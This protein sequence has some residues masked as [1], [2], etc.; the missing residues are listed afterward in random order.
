MKTKNLVVIAIIAILMAVGRL[1]VMNTSNPN[2]APFPAPPAVKPEEAAR[3]LSMAPMTMTLQAKILL[4]SRLEGREGKK[5]IVRISCPSIVPCPNNASVICQ[6][7]TFSFELDSNVYKNDAV[8]EIDDFTFTICK[9]GLLQ[10]VGAEMDTYG[11]PMLVDTF[12]TDTD[13]STEDAAT[14]WR[15]MMGIPSPAPVLHDEQ[16]SFGL[17]IRNCTLDLTR[18]KWLPKFND[19]DDDHDF[20]GELAH[21]EYKARRGSLWGMHHYVKTTRSLVR[22]IDQSVMADFTNWCL[23][24]TWHDDDT[25]HYSAGVAHWHGWGV[26]VNR[27]KAIALLNSSDSC[28]A[29]AK[30]SIMTCLYLLGDG[31]KESPDEAKT[32]LR[33]SRK[34]A[35]KTGKKDRDDFAL[36]KILEGGKWNPDTPTRHVFKLLEAQGFHNVR[37]TVSALS[38]GQ[39]NQLGQMLRV[40][41]TLLGLLGYEAKVTAP[42]HAA[43][44]LVDTKRLGHDIPQLHASTSDVGP[45]YNQTD[46]YGFPIPGKIA[47]AFYKVPGFAVITGLKY[48]N[49][50]FQIQGVPS[51]ESKGLLPMIFPEDIKVATALAFGYKDPVSA[52]LSLE[53]AKDGWDERN[54]QV[55]RKVFNPQWL[56]YTL[57]GKSLYW[58]DYL[59]KGLCV[60]SMKD[61]TLFTSMLPEYSQ[62]SLID[63][64]DHCG[65]TFPTGGGRNAIVLNGIQV[66]S[67]MRNGEYEAKIESISHGVEGSS[68]KM[69]EDGSEDRTLYWNDPKTHPGRFAKL[70]TENYTELSELFPPYE[71]VRQLLVLTKL[72]HWAREKGWM[73]AEEVRQQLYKYI[74]EKQAEANAKE[75][76]CMYVSIQFKPGYPAGTGGVSMHNA[77]VVEVPRSEEPLWNMMEKNRVPKFGHI[78]DDQK[79]FFPKEQERRENIHNISEAVWEVTEKIADKL[80]DRALEKMC[81][82]SN[83]TDNKL[84]MAICEMQHQ[85]D[86]ILKQP[87]NPP[88]A[89]TAG[90]V[91]PMM[92][93]LLLRSGKELWS[94]LF[95]GKEKEC[96]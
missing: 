56:A 24:S 12:G 43:M 27:E 49:G 76:E 95:G 77:T 21:A 44:T 40:K 53:G 9:H 66:S 67:Q 31:V 91:V 58:A 55:F 20:E 42:W 16:A 50:R 15:Q 25:C 5:R 75:G 38:A 36:L 26:E 19:E 69:N 72:L 68:I 13:D 62:P 37:N 79:P 11:D 80:N 33:K 35:E 3:I 18:A 93:A 88:L 10:L 85:G 54:Y 57:Y 61:P 46:K 4:R 87:E 89:A 81:S 92:A 14:A 7:K 90:P 1:S 2:F 84:T 71:R 82:S 83:W 94:G 73:P 32:L 59:M 39:V 70:M 23:P 6:L 78:P 29:E 30:Q 17:I 41:L 22:P 60:V 8:F 86:L 74:H 52:S 65:G 45:L 64:L 96:E 34:E 28:C 51:D 47:P 63:K 48:K